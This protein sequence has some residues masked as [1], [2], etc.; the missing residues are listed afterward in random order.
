MPRKDNALNTIYPP[1]L[2]VTEKL[3]A[4]EQEPIRQELDEEN[5][6]NGIAHAVQA[7]C[8]MANNDTDNESTDA[9]CEILNRHDSP[10]KTKNNH[11]GENKLVGSAEGIVEDSLN[12]SHRL[13]SR[14]RHRDSMS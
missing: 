1:L 3:S 14:Q 11:P 12:V 13:E 8:G 9:L 10:S 7:C 5:G 4:E 2:K 6:R